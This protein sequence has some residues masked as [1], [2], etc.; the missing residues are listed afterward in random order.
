[1]RKSLYKNTTMC[2]STLE[3]KEVSRNHSESLTL[4]SILN[5]FLALETSHIV[6]SERSNWCAL[7]EDLASVLRRNPR[8]VVYKI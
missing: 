1:M 5:L 2:M 3:L 7:L 6:C 8:T 4:I